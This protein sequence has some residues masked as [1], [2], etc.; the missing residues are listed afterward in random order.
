MTLEIIER[1]SSFI[2]FS[3][4]IGFTFLYIV[5]WMQIFKK[6]GKSRWIA[7]IPIY[8]IIVLL[9]ILNLPKWWIFLFIIPFINV[10]TLIFIYHQ[11]SIAFNKGVGF[12]IGLVLVAFIF[13]PILGLGKAQYRPENI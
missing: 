3:I 7:L 12:T 1:V 13:I 4:I 6:A 10:I 11:L 5:S 8:N 2:N 9:D